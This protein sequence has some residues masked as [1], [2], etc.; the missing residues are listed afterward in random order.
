MGHIDL[1]PQAHIAYTHLPTKRVLSRLNSI[2]VDHSRSDTLL[3]NSIR[4]S[5]NKTDTNCI[6]SSKPGSR[7]A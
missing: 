7:Y 2:G 1:D 5:Q 4:L 6:N 3:L